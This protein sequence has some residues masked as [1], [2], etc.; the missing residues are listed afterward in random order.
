LRLMQ[1][2]VKKSACEKR[3][4][5]KVIQGEKK[6]EPQNAIYG[7]DDEKPDTCEIEWV[8]CRLHELKLKQ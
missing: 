2:Q 4:E 5:S 7:E 6:R 1:S 3:G 8:L